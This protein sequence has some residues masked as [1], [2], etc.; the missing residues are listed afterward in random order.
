MSASESV[1]NPESVAISTD[2]GTVTENLACVARYAEIAAGG[3]TRRYSQVVL[4][5]N[6]VG[7][8]R[9]AEGLGPELALHR[10][11]DALPV[12]TELPLLELKAGLNRVHGRDV[13]HWPA[14]C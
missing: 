12:I 7:S 5:L 6:N 14:G 3:G 11:G 10:G 2:C 1:T 4:P 9:R 13:P 8:E